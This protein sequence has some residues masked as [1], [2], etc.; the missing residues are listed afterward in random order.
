MPDLYLDVLLHVE[1]L[2]SFFVVFCTGVSAVSVIL[3]MSHS[4]PA[5]WR[6]PSLMSQLQIMLD[7]VHNGPNNTSSL[8]PAYSIKH[9]RK[10]D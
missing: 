3:L 8:H 4:Q 5:S 1:H 10:P 6:I 2:Q 7:V 9:T